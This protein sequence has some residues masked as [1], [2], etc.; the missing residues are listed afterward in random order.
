VL[1]GE[2]QKVRLS[3]VSAARTFFIFSHGG[4]HKKTVS[5]TQRMLI[6][7]CDSGRL[8]AFEPVHLIERA[9]ARARRQL[10]ALS[11]DA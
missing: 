11:S 4:K 9:T 8:K 1:D 6:K 5:L 7:L 2:W 3:H 10:A